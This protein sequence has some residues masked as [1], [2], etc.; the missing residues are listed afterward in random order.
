MN[1]AT[2]ALLEEFGH[3]LDRRL[4]G[5]ADSPGNEGQLF[6]AD[7]TPVQYVVVN[8][9]MPVLSAEAAS[10]WDQALT[11]ASAYLA[12][13]LTRADRDTLLNNV[14]GRAGTEA[15][16]FEA[17]K[18]ALLEAIG[19]TGLRIAIDLHNNTEMQGAIGAYAQLGPN[20]NEQI[21]INADW[22]NAGNL[23]LEQLTAVLLE[24]YGHALD[25]RLNPGLESAGDEGELFANL[26]T[27]AGLNAD[28]I[29]AINSQDDWGTVQVDGQTVAVEQA[30]VTIT[31]TGT[32]SNV[33]NVS[34][35]YNIPA[36]FNVGSDGNPSA[37]FIFGNNAASRY[38]LTNS[39]EFKANSFE[40]T[41]T[42][43]YTIAN[44]GQFNFIGTG[45]GITQSSSANQTIS[46]G[47]KISDGP[48]TLGGIGTGLV[49]LSGTSND[50]AS[51]GLSKT[52]TSA[53]LLSSGN[54]L[55]TGTVTISG[56]T[57]A[58]SSTTILSGL[59]E[60]R[61]GV[62]A[63]SG[64]FSRGLGTGTNSVKFVENGGG[65]A[66][67]GGALRVSTALGTWASTTNG[68]AVSTP[69]ILGSRIADNVVTLSNTLNLGGAAR[70]IRLVDNT[71][72]LSD[73]AVM[74]GVI[75]GS[76]GGLTVTGSGTLTLSGANT[77][78]GVTTISGGILSVATIG[79]GG[80]AGNLGQS[81]NA[82]S[83]LVF[84][85]G[86]LRYTAATASTNRGF[87]LNAGKTGTLDVSAA[88][89]ALTMSGAS[90]NTTGALT[91]AGDGTLILSGANLHTGATTISAGT[92]QIGAGGT[93]GSLSTSSAITNNSALSFNRTDTLTQGTNFGTISGTGTLTQAGSGTLILRSAN[94]YTGTTTISA[95]AL[96]LQ[97]ATGLGTTAG[98]TTVAS[99]AALQIQNNITVG[100]EALTLSG[101]GQS[102]TGALLNVSGNN[103]YGGAITRAAATTVGSTAGTL[104][105][106]G[107]MTGNFATTF[108]GAGNITGSGVISGTGA[109]T[110]SGAGT[111]SL[112]G[113][114]T[115]SGAT[116]LSA[117]TLDISG[118]AGALTATSGVNI[119]G[120]TLLLSGSAADRISNGA[121][122]SLGGAPDT[123]LQLSGAVTETLGS[124]TLSSGSGFRV[125]D[126]G[127]TSGVLTLASLTAEIA[128]DL[129][130]WNW[131]GT[132]GTGGGTDQLIISSGSLGGELSTSNISFYS[133][134]GITLV[135]GAAGFNATSGELV[136]IEVDTIRPTIAITSNV[137]SLKAGETATITFTLS[138][139]STD[140]T[141]ADV[142]A[143][144]GTISN[145]AGSGTAYTATFTPTTDSTADG[146][147]SVAS[148]AFSDAAGNTNNDGGDANNTVTLTVDTIRPTIAITSNVSALKAGETA[149]IT[150]TLSE[151]ST[152]FTAADVNATGGTISDFAGS[153][154]AYTATFT[155]TADSTANGVISVASATFA[156]AAGN[157]NNDGA[158]TNNS[159]TLT[160]D[161][162]TPSAPSITSITDDISPLTGTVASGGSTNDTVLVIAGTAEANSTV[163]LYNGNTSLGTASANGSGAWSFTTA[164]LSNGSTY[165]FNATATDAAGNGS[166]ASANYTVTVD[167][168]AP[169][170]PVI[171]T[172]TDD[173][174]P[175]TGTIASGGS[176]N[177]TVLV[178]AGTAEANSTVTLY[179]GSTSLGTAS[180]NG[181]G[182]W[183]FTTATLS[184]GSTYSFNATA[185]DAAG[186][187][188]AAS[189]NYQVTVDTAAPAAPVLTLG[190]GVS[191]GAT[192][193][194][195]TAT[196]GVVTLTA[197]SGASVS[198]VFTGTS[199]TFTKTVTGNGATAVAVVL[200]AGDL[201]TLGNGSVSVSA[202]ATDAAGNASSAGIT[203]FTLD[204]VAPTLAIT[205]NV[206][207]LKAG[208][209]ASLTFTLSEASTDFT[210]ADVSATGG[211]ISNFAGSGTSYT[212]T[213]TPTANSTTNGV[214]SVASA[215]FSDA[216]G[217]TNQDGDDSNNTVTLTVDTLAP[218]LA[219]T[220]S[221][222]A[223]KAGE[224]ATITFT[225]SEDPTGF[226]A[227]DITTTGG[228]LSGLA[229]TGDTKIY[230]ATFTPTVGTNNGTA[231]ITVAAGNYT[232]A[233]GNN[234]G[235]G[236]TPSLTF[237]TL[238]PTAPTFAL[239]SDTGSSNSDGITNNGSV[240]V[241]G[242]EAGATWEFSTNGGDNWTPGTGTSF[243]LAEGTYT[244]G[245]IRVR[246][247]DLAGN[248]SPPSQNAAAITVD[249]TVPTTT[250]TVTS[251]NE[252][253]AGPVIGN[254]GTSNGT[255][256]L[257]LSGTL[258]S[259]LVEG[260]TIRV[261]DGS[262]FLGRATAIAGSAS[263]SYTDSRVLISG[264]Q[265]SYTARVANTA[266]NQ[267]ASTT[268]YVITQTSS[269][270]EISV[271]NVSVVEGAVGTTT[272]AAFTLR[273]SR[274]SN[275]PITV[276]YEFIAGTA[277]AGTDYTAASGPQTL[278][279]NPGVTALQ[280]VFTAIGDAI[281]ESDET[282]SL[283]LSNPT[284]ATFA[285]GS[286]AVITAATG[287]II[288][289]DD[290]LIDP[291][292]GVD[293][294]SSG[295]FNGTARNDTL[296]GNNGVNQIN[297]LAGNDTITGLGGADVLTGG[298]G[299]DTFRYLALTDST[300]AVLD[301]ITDF[302][303]GQGDKIDLPFTPSAVPNRG[304]ISAT[305]LQ[306]ALQLA[307][308][309]TNTAISG[310][311][312]LQVG[313]VVVFK[314]GTSSLRRNTYIA[315]SDGN[316]A[317]FNGDLL[318]KL[319]N[320]TFGAIDS[321]IFI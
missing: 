308:A 278:T 227:G 244:S 169:A 12:E 151:A 56:G 59:I 321:T 124:L 140:F 204:T 93:T 207:T 159:V 210:S 242:I 197:E 33:L 39:A 60:L 320:N 166:A 17:N 253:T 42:N 81:T 306:G 91:K 191:G 21:Y 177:D 219:I 152:D 295:N 135:S 223:L 69:L 188:S 54:A 115:Y 107:A 257:L 3:A 104:T 201:T 102:S 261:F 214:I 86:T 45:T 103:T 252:G 28:Q 121:S 149:T 179:N 38:S 53:F 11:Q 62:L 290:P 199:E 97:N 73:A 296:T 83:R 76:G 150:F 311:Q 31:W 146:V 291:S 19:T 46:G 5:G 40:F 299:A 202:T 70:E 271:N 109:V 64:T 29:A 220:S 272:Q 317:N 217:N 167:T 80:V 100:A 212:A 154:T 10:L 234:G 4:N 274:A 251:V 165:S 171:S 160:V 68:L 228:A 142:N 305:T 287:T 263:W 43:S 279:F 297:G 292:L 298:L 247:S 236:T 281:D 289:D 137:S 79:N 218:T 145:F 16:T 288:D 200:A 30:D 7:D 153:G 168:A 61:G 98:G 131:S 65:F 129:Q 55:T 111:L 203:S 258:S 47:I 162:A 273:L 50:Y 254:G 122:I 259:T 116:T 108:T 36:G 224:T 284:N 32:T 256:A 27:N 268:P 9:G 238:A 208:E 275:Q 49:T 277:I 282:L 84:D 157:T 176:T 255:A 24:E 260:E 77:Y 113:S 225:F 233:A 205:S 229:V 95:G 74:S 192:S 216:A 173:V 134:S 48:F 156:D 82:A 243:S 270:P 90:S 128:L 118:A 190:T 209:A 14:F 1:L 183:S 303:V 231:S 184:N 276:T 92:L 148:A 230:T 96:N 285:S 181:F 194:E 164:T 240:I 222:S 147:I 310:N 235:A 35:N 245:T 293:I 94:T 22:I 182:A 112:T 72:S 206:S 139:A 196:G 67:Y 313:E 20:G 127:S 280:V 161:T 120:G 249:T 34:S 63:T 144:G 158:D 267:S 226:D 195:A 41:G 211:T 136:A 300:L 138:E 78:T 18:Q 71:N 2:S 87:T 101:T 37:L 180:A 58:L 265:V 75:S 315:S 319:P 301:F 309:D 304:V 189:A 85:G 318:I 239:A 25:V 215:T 283:Q 172:I 23:S 130:I 294:T 123:K 316:P 6:A 314:W 143:T 133:D 110:K 186:N 106:S 221:A 178:L 52:G 246:Q 185:T 198:V 26:I 51:K 248:T 262:T 89:T 105:L 132:T 170:A 99:G 237:D 163:T 232:D 307:F 312:P 114:N 119:S 213:F 117:G 302:N 57:L 13:L 286:T 193:A 125:I 126:F 88:G 8:D 66:A 44:S 266:G 187:V 155:P 250:A 15:T 175:L 241:S 269:L 141:S 174:S 264:Q